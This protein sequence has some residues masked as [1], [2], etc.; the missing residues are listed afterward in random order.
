MPVCVHTE[1][2]PLLVLDEEED[3][4]GLVVQ[5]MK[6]FPSSEEVQLQGCC[7]LQVLLERGKHTPTHTN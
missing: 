3:V 7:A 1:L 6:T 5:A 4:F 2:L